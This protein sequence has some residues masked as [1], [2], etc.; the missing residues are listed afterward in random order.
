MFKVK[1]EVGLDRTA[2]GHLTLTIAD[3][4]ILDLILLRLRLRF[5]H[6]FRR[7]GI[8]IFGPDEQIA[9][10]FVRG[11]LRLLAGYDDWSGL[12]LLAKDEQ[13]DS[14]LETFAREIQV[15]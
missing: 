7:E 8:R 13:G 14:F 10:D 9:P 6:G 4:G 3:P 1:G 11:N 15:P 5:L 2:N 12:Y